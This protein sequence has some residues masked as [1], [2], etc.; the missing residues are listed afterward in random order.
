L[1]SKVCAEGPVFD[2]RS[3]HW[4]AATLAPACPPHCEEEQP[5]LS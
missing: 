1:P 4:Q 2:A 3:I 5:C